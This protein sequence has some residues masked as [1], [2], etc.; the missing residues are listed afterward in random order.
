M[1]GWSTDNTVRVTC[2]G[3]DPNTFRYCDQSQLNIPFRHDFKFAGSYGL[4]LDTEI[5]A[6]LQSYAGRDLT[7]SWAVPAN[8]FPG[9]RTQAV[10][11]ALIPPGSKYLKR[12]NQLD[13]SLRKIFTVG[14]LRL[15]GSLDIYNALNSNVVLVENQNFGSSLGQPQ[16]I[17]QGRLLRV[18]G[19]LKF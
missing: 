9:G 19:Q 11:V 15:E 7:V 4:P 12:W 17:L 18:T 1:G 8:L 3:D 6:A 5:G 13:L 2:D 14:N 16:Q 10:T